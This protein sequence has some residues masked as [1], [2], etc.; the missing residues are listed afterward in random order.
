MA[1]WQTCTFKLVD[2]TT[3]TKTLTSLD[4]NTQQLFVQQIPRNGGFFDDS[5]VFHPSSAI[6]SIVLT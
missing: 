2:S 3:V 4:A 5:G 6:V 1:A